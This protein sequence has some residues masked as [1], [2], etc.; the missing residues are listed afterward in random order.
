MARRAGELGL[1]GRWCA[2]AEALESA[3]AASEEAAAGLM[4]DENVP[5]AADASSLPR[6]FCS[7][8]SFSRSITC[9]PPTVSEGSLPHTLLS[10][11]SNSIAK[12][13]PSIVTGNEFCGMLTSGHVTEPISVTVGRVARSWI[14]ETSRTVKP[15]APIDVVVAKSATSERYAR[16]P[17]D[18]MLSPCDAYSCVCHSTMG[19]SGSLTSIAVTPGAAVVAAQ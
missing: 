12:S 5:A 2:L 13:R 6:S 3:G 16:L 1:R 7:L 17:S 10:Y 19:R 11:S 14:S 4:R 18:E 8:P 15:P 9:T